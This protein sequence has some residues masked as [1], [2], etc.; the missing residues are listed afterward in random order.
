MYPKLGPGQLWEEVARQVQEMGGEIFF[1]S[2]ISGI[3]IADGKVTKVAVGSTEYR[4]DYL[5]SSMPIKELIQLIKPGVPDNVKKIADG[6]IYRDFITTGILL[7]KLLLN[8]DAKIPTVNDIVPDNWIYIQE[9]DVRVG[10]LQIFNNWSPYMIQDSNTVWIGAEYF[11]NEGDDLWTKND[12][13]MKQYAIEE[14]SQIGIINKK[15]VLDSV[16]IRMPKAYPAYFGT[17]DHFNSIRDYLDSID[18]LFAIGRNGMRKYNNTDHSMLTAMMAV[19]CV[20]KLKNKN[21][22]W[23]VNTEKEYHE[24]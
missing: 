15:D 19:D 9:K 5:F 11:C 16:V 2:A 10:R 6:L 17:Y 8:N 1:N 20:M 23:D 7:K 3:D 12:A 24:K 18:N 13:A 14:L 4:P 22:I 21:D